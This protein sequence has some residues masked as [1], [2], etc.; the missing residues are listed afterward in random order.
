MTAIIHTIPSLKHS[1]ANNRNG[2]GG[3]RPLISA[4]A[5]L[6]SWVKQATIQTNP[7]HGIKPH[8]SSD[9]VMTRVLMK[10]KIGALT[11]KG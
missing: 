11:P 8:Q 10:A 2:R 4:Y 6:A 5:N 3:K 1:T 7:K 9:D